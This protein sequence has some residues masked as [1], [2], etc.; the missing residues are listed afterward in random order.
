[1]ERLKIYTIG[2]MAFVIVTLFWLYSEEK[3]ERQRVETNQTAL[4]T[5][6]HRY[7]TSDSLN[8]VSVQELTLSKQELKKH[9]AELVA[10][11]KELGIKVKRLESVTSVSTQANYDF[12]PTKKDS[13]IYLPG[14]DSIIYLKC[15]EYKDAWIDFVGCYDKNNIPRVSMTT[16]DSIDIFGH[17][18]PKRFWFIKYGVKSINSEV[19]NYNPYSEIKYSKVIKLKK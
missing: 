11:V 12:T 18:V 4:L 7:K 8:A 2:I 10:R 17:V 15:L 6:L 9:E 5:D 19:I 16:N 3:E 1:M 14:K 13:I